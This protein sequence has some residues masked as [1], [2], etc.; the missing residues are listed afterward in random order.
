MRIG[1]TGGA[2]T[3]DKL[4]EQAQRAEADGFTSLW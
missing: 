3:V 4:V 1:L 2:S